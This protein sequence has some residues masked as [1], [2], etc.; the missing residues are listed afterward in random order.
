MIHWLQ[1]PKLLSCK[2]FI[3]R[4]SFISTTNSIPFIYHNQNQ[5]F[6]AYEVTKQLADLLLLLSIYSLVTCV[7]HALFA[8]FSLRPFELQ[9]IFGLDASSKAE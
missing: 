9:P 6:K 8:T 3:E 4:F 1:F 2:N 5:I 7:N